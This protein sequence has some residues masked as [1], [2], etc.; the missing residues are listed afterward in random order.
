MLSFSFKKLFY[1][2]SPENLK[3]IIIIDDSRNLSYNLRNS[4]NLN[5]PMAKTKSVRDQILQKNK[6]SV[7]NYQIRIF[8]TSTDD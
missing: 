8:K 2:N 1:H 3:D 4:A 5:E 7:R 6:H